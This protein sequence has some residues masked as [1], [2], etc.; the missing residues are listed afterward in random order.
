MIESTPDIGHNDI[1]EVNL[2]N[3]TRIVWGHTGFGQSLPLN[4]LTGQSVSMHFT[5]AGTMLLHAEGLGYP[6]GIRAKQH[7]I[8]CPAGGNFRLTT[9]TDQPCQFLQIQLV[10]DFSGQPAAVY[11]PILNYLAGWVRTLQPACLAPRNLPVTPDMHTVLMQITKCPLNCTLK[12]LFLEA[13]VI[14]LLA[15]QLGQYEQQPSWPDLDTGGPKYDKVVEARRL[16]EAR[17]DNPPTLPELSHLVGLNECKL[18]KQFKAAFGETVHN[19]VLNYRLDK[20]HQLLQSS[21]LTIS[22]VAYRVGYQHPAHFTTAFKKK[23]GLVPSRLLMKIIRE[24]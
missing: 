23:F 15:L 21:Q 7:I 12:R 9:S 1:Q 24:V 2:T 19:W 18:K 17:F 5:L 3:G 4:R 11:S 14:E 13:K 16:L 22:E 10:P 6:V 8:L 20:A